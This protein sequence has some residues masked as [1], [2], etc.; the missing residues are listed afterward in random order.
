MFATIS[1]PQFRGNWLTAILA[2]CHDPPPAIS[3]VFP[4]GYKMSLAQM[5]PT[6][7]RMMG[8]WV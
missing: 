2:W 7:R 3:L 5:N 8:T 1:T 4:T 6:D